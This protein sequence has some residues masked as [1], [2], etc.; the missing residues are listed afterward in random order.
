MKI[1]CLYPAS[2]VYVVLEFKNL[3]GEFLI[4]EFPKEQ[5]TTV[6]YML[7]QPY[8]YVYATVNK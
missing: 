2:F 5:K 4:L 1:W 8:M 7:I 6:K 3:W